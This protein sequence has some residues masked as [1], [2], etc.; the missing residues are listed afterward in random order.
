MIA[1][2]PGRL[3]VAAVALAAAF[4]AG[5][6]TVAGAD[7]DT[8]R[9]Q[10]DP[11]IDQAVTTIEQHAAKPVPRA[12]LEHAAVE[13]M[14][15]AL[16]DQWANYYDRADYSRMR[17]LMGGSY[18]GVGL[19]LRETSDGGMRVLSVQT[20]SPAQRSGIRA[21]DRIVAVAG[22]PV[23]GRT[24]AQLSDALR[25]APGTD[26]RVTVSRPGGPI[27]TL[28]LRRSRMADHDVTT[29]M[30]SHS[31]ERIHIAAF[32]AGVGSR[33]RAL[34]AQAER[35]NL[36]GLVLDLRDNPGGLLDEAVETASAFLHG[37]PVVTYVQRGQAPRTLDV[38]GRGDTSMP[39]VVLVDGGTASAAE[40][41]AAALQERGRAVL[42]GSQTFGKG[43]VQAPEP[44]AN[45]G[46]V[47]LTVGHYLTPSG[48][49]LEGVGIQPD[50][51]IPPRTAQSVVTARALEVLAGLTA[52][53]GSSGRG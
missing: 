20:G 17:Q 31:V 6:A 45:G 35:R 25:G 15:S 43:T 38:L 33:V 4:G 32:T 5:A 10:A 34:V 50:V 44:L 2:R 40:I 36:S 49:S 53:S 9:A 30:L 41:V 14:L 13:G 22:R 11:V 23:A 8:H 3:A 52:D 51:L 19:W 1:S 47:E 39:L 28:E 46:A 12:K 7:S 42:L 16:N 29:S 21:G 27:A 48:R 18:T 24:V 37:G 26:V